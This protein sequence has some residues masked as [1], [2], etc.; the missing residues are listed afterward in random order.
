M[1]PR[2][3]Q[4]FLGPLPLLNWLLESGDAKEICYR[5]RAQHSHTPAPPGGEGRYQTAPDES[6]R[7]VCGRPAGGGSALHPPRDPGA[8]P[9]PGPPGA[10][11]VLATAWPPHKSSPG[12]PGGFSLV[13]MQGGAG[14]GRTALRHL[15]V[16]ARRLQASLEPDAWAALLQSAREA[17]DCADPAACEHHFCWRVPEATKVLLLV[18]LQQEA[19]PAPLARFLRHCA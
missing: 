8:G 17:L 7:G 15:A 6:G 11:P 2:M 4:T 13:L 16:R 18:S 5:L 10:R 1:K 3:V 9:P 14:G 19:G 12:P